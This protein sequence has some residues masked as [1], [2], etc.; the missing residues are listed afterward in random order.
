[1]A[2]ITWFS[3][4][5]VNTIL[6]QNVV[7]SIVVDAF[8]DQKE[9]AATTSELQD[10]CVMCCFATH[11]GVDLIAGDCRRGG[12]LESCCA[13]CR[14]QKKTTSIKK[15]SEESSSSR[16]RR[17][18]HHFKRI[19]RESIS[20]SQAKTEQVHRMEEAETCGL[21]NGKECSREAWMRM[22]LLKKKAARKPWAQDNSIDGNANPLAKTIRL[23][24]LATLRSAGPQP[25]T[26]REIFDRYDVDKS[27]ELCM[28][29]ELPPALKDMGLNPAGDFSQYDANHTGTISFSE[30]MKLV[31]HMVGETHI[32]KEL[33]ATRVKMVA[34]DAAYVRTL[35]LFYG[36]HTLSLSH[37]HTHTH[38]LSLAL[39]FSHTH[40][41]VHDR[42]GCTQ[43]R[44]AECCSDGVAAPAE[45]GPKLLRTT[46]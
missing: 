31:A 28:M 39:A 38:I 8:M 27:G 16:K 21:M 22:T 19:K 35:H 5:M 11:C 34:T 44:D 43:Q 6:L 33:D 13:L 18:R 7:L 24:R 45:L 2:L 32:H 36:T 10:D 14:R 4:V 37:T 40:T 15:K 29:M 42:S 23:P 46:S 30:Y 26:Q 1:M 3:F 41:Q 25:E 17:D 12:C 20:P 9:A